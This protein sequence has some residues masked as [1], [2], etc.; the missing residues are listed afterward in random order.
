MIKNNERTSYETVPCRRK[1]HEDSDL[2][3]RSSQIDVAVFSYP[4][5]D[6]ELLQQKA[7]EFLELLPFR[8]SLPHQLKLLP[9]RH[10]SIKFAASG[11][12]QDVL[13]FRDRHQVVDDWPVGRIRAPAVLARGVVQDA[14]LHLHRATCPTARSCRSGL[15]RHA[16]VALSAGGESV[17]EHHLRADP[18]SRVRFLRAVLQ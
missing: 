10:F 6:Q 11:Y 3:M 8:S 17:A 1:L 2:I 7:Q 12:A 18:A 5:Q 9:P 13:V 14:A 4:D 16:E 15:D